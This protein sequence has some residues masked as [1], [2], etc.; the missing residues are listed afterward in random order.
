[1]PITGA[2]TML[3]TMPIGMPAIG[4]QPPA[5]RPRAAYR[6]RTRKT[7]M[8]DRDLPGIAADDVP[9]RSRDRRQQKRHAD[10]EIKRPRKNERIE[11]QPRRQQNNSKAWRSEL[12]H[13]RFMPC[14]SR[15]LPSGLAAGTTI[16]RRTTRRRRCT[17]RSAPSQYAD[18][19][20]IRPMI[21]PAYSE[22]STLPKPPNATTTNAM[23]LNVSP[24]EGD[25]G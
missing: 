5:C 18:T 20:W 24:T 9:G 8:A 6:R 3:S 7:C 19:A 14:L 16:A 4:G 2:S 12:G 17:Y 21:S 25:H 15:L 11:Q 1:M 10:V 13:G 22:P 23:R